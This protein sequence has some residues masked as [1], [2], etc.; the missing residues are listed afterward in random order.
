MAPDDFKDWI[1]CS[2]T[3]RDLVTKRLV[4]QFKATLTPHL[5]DTQCPPGFHWCLAVPHHLPENLGPDGTEKKGLFLPP[6]DLPLRRWWGGELQICGAFSIGDEIE[7]ISRVVEIDTPPRSH[8][9][10][11]SVTIEHELYVG[12]KVMVR[13]TQRLVFLAIGMD[14]KLP[15]RVTDEQIAAHDLRWHVVA[16]EVRLFRYSA[17]TFNGHRIHYDTPFASTEG[18][19]GPL[20]HGPLQATLLLNQFAVLKKAVP[21]Q[22]SY[23]C[24]SPLVAPQQAQVVARGLSSSA[25]G[26][27]LTED[28]FITTRATASW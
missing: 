2:V 26:T 23:Q 7:R 24:L 1:G 16:D 21:K 4:E 11:T 13:E 14:G 19:R 15:E 3:R 8:K 28:G 20:V 10:L 27:I 17:L 22:F 5:F 6:I 25:Q 12:D 18:Q 9:F